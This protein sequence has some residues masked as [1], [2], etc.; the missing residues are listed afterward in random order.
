[1]EFVICQPPCSLSKNRLTFLR[2]E[3]F[4]APSNIIIREEVRNVTST[5]GP[6]VIFG[7]SVGYS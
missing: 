2:C 4:V 6:L 1:M 3:Y 7:K 5:D